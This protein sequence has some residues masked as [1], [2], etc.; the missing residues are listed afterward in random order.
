VESG[1]VFS[2]VEQYIKTLNTVE[3]RYLTGTKKKNSTHQ[4]KII[5]IYYTETSIVTRVRDTKVPRY[6]YLINYSFVI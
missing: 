6:L 3:P 2:G 5:V 4:N 1:T